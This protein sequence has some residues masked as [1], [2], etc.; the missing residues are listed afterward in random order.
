MGV[1]KYI[2]VLGLEEEE[3]CKLFEHNFGEENLYADPHV[4]VLAKDLVREL[5]D[6]PSE[7]IHFGKIMRRN[8]DAR[9][10]EVAIDAVKRSNLRKDNPLCMVSACI[11]TQISK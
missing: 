6:Q 10:W 9:Q 11:K 2:Q 7:L 5:M 3:A 8:R 4:G 1:D